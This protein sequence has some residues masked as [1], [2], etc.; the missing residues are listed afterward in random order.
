MNEPKIWAF[1]GIWYENSWIWVHEVKRLVFSLYMASVYTHPIHLWQRTS[2]VYQDHPRFRWVLTS[3]V[4]PAHTQGVRL[5]PTQGYALWKLFPP[6][7]G[8]FFVFYL[9]TSHVLPRSGTL[10][11]TFHR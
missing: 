10:R 4:P 1:L 5:A 6:T 2:R 11:W 9:L 3:F 8:S 7:A